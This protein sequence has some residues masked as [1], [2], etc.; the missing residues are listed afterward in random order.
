MLL[1][2]PPALSRVGRWTRRPWRDAIRAALSVD[3]IV[4]L[5]EAEVKRGIET[6]HHRAQGLQAQL[7]E[8]GL[9]R[10]SSDAV[11][12]FLRLLANYD[13]STLAAATAPPEMYLDYFVADS[14]VECERDHLRVGRQRVKVLSMK[15]APAQTFAHVLE[16]LYTVPG[17]FIACLEWQRLANDRSNAPRPAQPPAPLVPQ[18]RVDG[19][20]CVV[21]RAAPGRA[22]ARRPERRGDRPDQLGDALTA[23]EVEGHFLWRVLRH[24]RPL[25][26]RGPRRRAGGRG[27]SQGAGHPRRR[28]PRR[29]VQPRE[30]VGQ[31]RPGEQ[32]V[33]T[34]AGSRSSRPTARI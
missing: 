7:V 15:E 23:M 12:R 3:E 21:V 18:T 32:H 10:Q 14:P 9:E 2:E 19:E 22:A 31:H 26:P 29:D 20:L 17:E 4:T 8:L 27:S 6:L 34:C 24:A 5:L 11:F 16:D 30:R 25:R 33:Q 1:Y 28:L 13:A